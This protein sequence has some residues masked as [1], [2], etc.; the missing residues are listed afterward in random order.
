MRI[1]YNNI[2]DGATITSYSENPQ[3][4]FDDAFKD[5]RL[6]RVGRTVGHDTEWIKFTLPSA[7]AATY[8]LIF[9]HNL[10]A[11][12][13]VKL[14]GNATDVWTSPSF[15]ETLTV[16]DIINKNFTSASYKYWRLTIADASNP[17]GYIQIS[18]VIIGT[19]LQMPGFNRVFAMPRKSTSKGDKSPSGQLYG[20]KRIIFTS[21][22]FKFN[23]VSQANK[24]LIDAFFDI[25]ETIKPFVLLVWENSLTTQ[26]P[27]Y[28]NLTDDLNWAMEDS[29]GLSWSFTLP[30]E[31]CF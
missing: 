17:D 9:G 31:Q 29:S 25:V 20:D 27:I 14:E 3:Y 16:I 15:S 12:A 2:I 18:K 21:A 6:S 22:E 26:V 13:T 19:Y 5:S 10:T 1:I 30:V 24:V 23:G 4:L 8:I 11:G 28:C 7:A